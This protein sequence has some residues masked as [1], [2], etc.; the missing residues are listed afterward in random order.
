M[1]GAPLA[2][3]LSIL[4]RYEY[5]KGVKGSLWGVV[6]PS[7]TGESGKKSAPLLVLHRINGGRW[8]VSTLPIVMQLGGV[9]AKVEVCAIGFRGVDYFCSSTAAQTTPFSYTCIFRGRSIP[10]RPERLVTVERPLPRYR[11]N[12]LTVAIPKVRTTFNAV[13]VHLPPIQ[14][15]EL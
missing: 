13:G 8:K 2:A 14:I 15:Q 10:I 12:T 4:P 9:T 5:L 11:A 1:K 3:L 7:P 6:A